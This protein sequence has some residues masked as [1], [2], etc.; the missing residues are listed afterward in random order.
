MKILFVLKAAFNPNDGGVQRTTYKL[1]KDF[2]RK[3][4]EVS[5]FSLATS[6]HIDPEY[7][8][9][10]WAKQE[11]G[12]NS[13]ENLNYLEKVAAQLKPDIVINQ[14]PYLRPLRRALYEQKVVH[15]YRLLS[16]LRNSLFSFKD[17][18][19]DIVRQQVGPALHRVVDNSL[20]MSVIQKFHWAKHRRSLKDILDCSDYFILLA[21]PN[22][23]ELEHFVGDYKSEKVLSIPNSIPVVH[24][25]PPGLKKTMVHVGRLDVYQKRSDLLLKVWAAVHRALPEWNLV[26]VGDGPYKEKIDSDIE[27]QRLPRVETVGRRDPNPFY[28][29]ASIFIMTSA[30]EGFPN[31]IMEAQSHS[32]VPVAFNSYMALPWIVND[33]KD[34]LL[35]E[36]FDIPSFAEKVVGLAKNPER[37]KKMSQNA[38]QNARRFLTDEVG[39]MWL[40]F[41]NEIVPER[42][43]VE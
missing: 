31:V 35:A 25:V 3:G 37:L 11:G 4:L 14:N 23:K 38:N 20:G 18:A 2:T 9:L 21:P 34:A 30:F 40:R 33:G 8:S 36:P 13:A 39:N 27:E 1:G 29:D 41:F 19:S 43:S 28:S 22:K 26:I 32:L 24:E 10:F 5:Y 6:G 17:N 42:I 16:C 7:G 15:G 12:E